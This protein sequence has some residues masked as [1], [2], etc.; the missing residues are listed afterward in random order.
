[1][2]LR[3]DDEEDDEWEDQPAPLLQAA[4]IEPSA[5]NDTAASSG[6]GD[7]AAATA[8]GGM[9][10]R[11]RALC[12][13][14]EEW[15]ALVQHKRR[16]GKDGAEGGAPGSSSARAA[17]AAAAAASH[18]GSYS[19]SGEGGGDGSD[20]AAGSS[21]GEDILAANEADTQRLLRGMC[22]GTCVCAR[23]CACICS[24]LPL[25][26][27]HTACTQQPSSRLP[28][29]LFI[30]RP[31]LFLAHLFTHKL[32]TTPMHT[33]PSSSLQLMLCC[34]QSLLTWRCVY[35]VMLRVFG[36]ATAQQ[37]CLGKGFKPQVAPLN[38]LLGRL[39]ARQAALEA[40]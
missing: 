32:P 19:G 21:E 8:E 26:T 29:S 31:S 11:R 20:S 4:D 15:E 13:D 14:E 27:Q 2:V 34:L 18:S 7:G 1:V 35:V 12:D 6:D 24:H 37:D 28:N 25:A 10:D 40:R 36:A 30:A 16:S 3:D 17:A 22:I 9:L 33:S 5:R 23:A 38:S 39:N